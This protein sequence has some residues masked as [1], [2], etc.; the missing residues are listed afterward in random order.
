MKNRYVNIKPNILFQLSCALKKRDC[1]YNE[2]CLMKMLSF[3]LYAVSMEKTRGGIQLLLKVFGKM[4]YTSLV[5]S[6]VV[7]G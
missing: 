2:G 5:F 1:A 7:S 4:F 3:S 6:H